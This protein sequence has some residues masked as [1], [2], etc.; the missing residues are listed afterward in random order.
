MTP[1]RS[2]FADL[3]VLSLA[4]AVAVAAGG[5]AGKGALES[6]ELAAYGDDS[7]QTE[8]NLD[9]VT[10][11]FVGGSGAQIVVEPTAGGFFQPSGC[12]VE[13]ITPSSDK[14]T[15]TFNDCTGPWG[16]VHLTGVV[17][18]TWTQTSDSELDL[19]LTSSDFKINAATI[20]T[21]SAHADVTAHGEARTMTWSASLAGTTGGGRPFTR[22]NDKTLSWTAGGSCLSING[23]S[24]GTITGLDLETKLEGYSRCVG[25][26]PASGSEVTIEDVT[27][28]ATVDLKYLSAG[29]AQFTSTRGAVTDF[30]V[31]CGQ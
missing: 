1:T 15:Y 6:A 19:V 27:T 13:D 25:A 7:I 30:A 4:S 5:C 3:A 2:R 31:A 21:W 14:A 26:C 23:T 22:Q 28:G 9:S 24:T 20:T 8:S 29:Q 11:S 12:L 10:Q 16:L 17:D 18:A